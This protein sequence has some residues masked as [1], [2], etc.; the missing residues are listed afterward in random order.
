MRVFDLVPAQR[1]KG[2]INSGEDA[3]CHVALNCKN[4]LVHA[5]C[6]SL[7]DNHFKA[8]STVR[9]M[10]SANMTVCYY[11]IKCSKRAQIIKLDARYQIKRMGKL[12]KCMDRDYCI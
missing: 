2:N 7:F 6:C 9:L 10:N 5:R 12:L 1:Q 11:Q 8:I 4:A 3:Q